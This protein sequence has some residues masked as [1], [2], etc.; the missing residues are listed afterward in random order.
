MANKLPLISVLIPA[1]NH[2][3]YV[4]EAVR[5][6]WEQSYPNI[7]I[8]VVDDASPD[9]TPKILDNL[10][11]ISPIPMRVYLNET[12]KGPTATLNRALKLSE[13]DFI[14]LLPSDDKFAPRR[15]ESQVQLF[16][17]DPA[18]M[19]VY[20]NGRTFS[21]EG[22]GYRLHREKVRRKL[23]MDTGD[24][25]DYLYT[26]TS[27]FFLQTALI[28]RNLIME[29][30]GLDE[31]LVADDWVLNIK[32]FRELLR[33]GGHFACVDEDLVYYRVH[34]GNVHKDFNRQSKLKI[35]VIE[36]LTP[37]PLKKEAFANIYWSIGWTILKR[38]NNLK[39]AFSYLAKSQQSKLKISRLIKLFWFVITH[40]SRMITGKTKI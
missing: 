15:F 3:L 40:P 30:G 26:H 20:G 29:V 10:S 16:V 21:E 19:I 14:A 17:N 24:I 9:S 35:E 31:S 4:E 22:P 1:Y 28:K 32:I 13:G 36:R 39:Q 34:E 5:S 7:E 38:H 11:K 8:V 18:L 33:S 12:N 6:V 25:L 27:P 37:A 23:S 2:E